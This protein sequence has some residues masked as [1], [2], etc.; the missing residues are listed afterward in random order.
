MPPKLRHKIAFSPQM[1]GFWRKK[2]KRPLG[3]KRENFTLKH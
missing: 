2:Q 3:V 1:K